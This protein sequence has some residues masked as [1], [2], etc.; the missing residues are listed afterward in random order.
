MFLLSANITSP[1]NV[2]LLTLIPE[3]IVLLLFIFKFIVFIK[4]KQ[5]FNIKEYLFALV[6]FILLTLTKGALNFSTFCY[7]KTIFTFSF[8]ILN[9][10]S[11][12]ATTNQLYWPILTFLYGAFLT[13]NMFKKAKYL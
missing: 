10:S 11:Y 7:D 6:P 2:T 4:N 8:F 5:L 3:F 1:I 12:F 9:Y 13:Y